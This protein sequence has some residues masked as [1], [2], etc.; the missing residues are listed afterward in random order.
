[1]RPSP[2]SSLESQQ[3]NVIAANEKALVKFRES[4]IQIK[5][6]NYWSNLEKDWKKVNIGA[7]EVEINCHSKKKKTKRFW[8]NCSYKLI[9]MDLVNEM[10]TIQGHFKFFWRALDVK[11]D[12]LKFRRFTSG[13]EG[14]EV[15]PWDDPVLTKKIGKG[16]ECHGFLFVDHGANVLPIDPKKIF[17]ETSQ[18]IE[19]TWV[20]IS[21]YGLIQMQI[22]ATIKAPTDF[23]VAHYPFDR[24]AMPL[25]LNTRN[26]W[27]LFEK[28]PIKVDAWWKEL[29]E[30]KKEYP[31]WDETAYGVSDLD[32][33]INSGYGELHQLSS[34]WLAYTATYK[35][36]K[37]YVYVDWLWIF[38]YPAIHLRNYG[39]IPYFWFKKENKDTKEIKKL[40]LDAFVII[41]LQR[42]PSY[43]FWNVAFPTFLIVLV[44]MSTFLIDPVV[45]NEDPLNE[46]DFDEFVVQLYD[47][48]AITVTTILA[49]IQ[50]RYVT[51]GLIPQKSYSTWADKYLLVALLINCLCYAD[52]LMVYVDTKHFFHPDLTF[53][54]RSRVRRFLNWVMFGVWTTLHLVLYL[55]VL[56]FELRYKNIDDSFQ[57]GLIH[58]TAWD[59]EIAG[60]L[61]TGN[62]LTFGELY[63]HKNVEIEIGSV[64]ATTRTQNNVAYNDVAI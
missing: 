24:H 35:Q 23:S 37:E 50:M 36:K 21:Q 39:W 54:Y 44:S 17:Q 16:S 8:M 38:P 30:V 61:E 2:G 34:M 62:K 28:Y 32:L 25:R 18:E 15:N 40:T 42:L 63:R 41:R 12:E 33:E 9:D 26:G 59:K 57:A 22:N 58:R 3:L 55:D 4:E 13:S 7:G 56:W 53:V 49:T 11:V 1:M 47:Y 29:K 64:P 46:D 5:R 20:S 48:S 43:F 6:E 27:M 51:Q 14:E 52:N 19:S 31:K 45:H 60:V 10:F